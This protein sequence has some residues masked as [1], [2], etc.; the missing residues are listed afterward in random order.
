MNIVNSDGSLA[1]LKFKCNLTGFTYNVIGTES[2]YISGTNS[3][4]MAKDTIKREDGIKRT[5]TRPKLKERF[6][7]I[8]IL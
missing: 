2:T 1:S 8:T 6:N 7:N 3:P 4:L 5:L